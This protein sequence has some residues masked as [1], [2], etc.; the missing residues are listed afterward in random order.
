MKSG[1]IAARPA[2]LPESY[3]FPYYALALAA[4][5]VGLHDQTIGQ[6]QIDGSHVPVEKRF[7]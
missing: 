4:A 6:S 2:I 1:W 7:S 5:I 3:L